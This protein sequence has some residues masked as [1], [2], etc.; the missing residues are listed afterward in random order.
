MTSLA[1]IDPTYQELLRKLILSGTLNVVER[2]SLGSFGKLPVPKADV[3]EIIKETLEEHGIFPAI[4][5]EGSDGAI[6][7]GFQLEIIAQNRI[8]LQ[9]QRSSIF[10][11]SEMAQ[12]KDLEFNEIK[13][14][15]QKFI[16]LEWPNG[17]DGIPLK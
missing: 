1:N 6:Y 8:R 14:G 5:K 4:A 7:E 12:K 15:I 2:K 10:N 3:T 17:I 13:A 11:P 16:E 9:V